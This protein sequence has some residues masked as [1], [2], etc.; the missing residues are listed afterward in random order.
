MVLYYIP[1]EQIT[2]AFSEESRV[3]GFLVLGMAISE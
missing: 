2:K 3:T 1:K